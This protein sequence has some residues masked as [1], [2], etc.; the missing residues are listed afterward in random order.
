MLVVIFMIGKGVPPLVLQTILFW[1]C[2][3]GLI[4]ALRWEGIGGLLALD[5]MAG[6]YPGYFTNTI[7]RIANSVAQWAL[8]KKLA[9]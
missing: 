3:A 1:D 5:G 8:P 6:F 2:L 9:T 7:P 4:V